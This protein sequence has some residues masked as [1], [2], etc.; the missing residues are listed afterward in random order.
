M[1]D[2]AAD[3]QERGRVQAGEDFLVEAVAVVYVQ[4]IL[5]DAV[6]EFWRQSGE[7]RVVHPV[8]V[9]ETWWRCRWFNMCRGTV[10]EVEAGGRI[11][12]KKKHF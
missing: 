4:D 11:A 7:G 6:A 9:L 1:A 10:V 2:L 5:L 12:L 8:F 3:F